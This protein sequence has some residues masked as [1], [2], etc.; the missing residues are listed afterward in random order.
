MSFDGN[1][2]P[3]DEGLT[4]TT[5]GDLHGFSSENI[6]VPVGSDSYILSS[7]SGETTGVEWIANTDAGLTLGAKG[8][9]HT[10][11]A[12][13]QLALAVSGNNGYILSENSTTASGLEWI[14]NSSGT[15]FNEVVRKTSD[16]SESGT[17]PVS[18]TELKLAI[19][20][21]KTFIFQF[22]TILHETSTGDIKIS[23]T[24]PTNAT[25]GWSGTNS[26]TATGDTANFGD[27][28]FSSN[29]TDT[30]LLHHIGGWCTTDA[31][32]S[33]DIQF[34][35][36]KRSGSGATVS[37]TGGMGWSADVT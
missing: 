15:T 23:V 21:S 27:V 3:T 29:T 22:D 1:L 9:I 18:D 36:S 28:Q 30:M 2:Y 4:L 20:T 19:G 13:D 25:G 11:S 5:K 8:D 7:N 14:A 32:N 10:R 24:A 35:F 33:G 26:N 37:I 31:S 34:Q 16:Q 6:R 12:S 17:T